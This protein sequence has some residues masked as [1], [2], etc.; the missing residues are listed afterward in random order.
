MLTPVPISLMWYILT[1]HAI[2]KRLCSSEY[3]LPMSMITNG[4]QQTLFSTNSVGLSFQQIETNLTPTL[5][6]TQWTNV[7]I[8]R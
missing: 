2:K 3:Y 1:I 6:V 7:K 5:V 8:I 4:N